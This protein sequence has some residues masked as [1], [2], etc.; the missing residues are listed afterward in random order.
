MSIFLKAP[1]A[2]RQRDWRY[3][4]TNR[5]GSRRS[6]AT[7]PPS[8]SSP[9]SHADVDS[10]SI[11]PLSWSPSTRRPS[12][13]GCEVT[14]F[15]S[16]IARPSLHATNPTC[17]EGWSERKTPPSQAVQRRP[18]PVNSRSWTSACTPTP[19]IV[20]AAACP[21]VRLPSFM[22]ISAMTIEPL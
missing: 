12:Q 11:T 8:P 14:K 5:L 22:P 19:I 20:G 18:D 15:A 10:R 9:S 4:F 2:S 21:N 3:W 13:A 16:A 1:V 7:P 6:N 17:S